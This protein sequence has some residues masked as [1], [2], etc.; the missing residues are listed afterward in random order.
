M[1]LSS[2]AL[3]VTL[4]LVS[5]IYSEPLNPMRP[6]VIKDFDSSPKPLKTSSA[7]LVSPYRAALKSKS[8]ANDSA[9]IAVSP[10]SISVSSVSC[11]LKVG[12]DNQEHLDRYTAAPDDTRTSSRLNMVSDS[13]SSPLSQPDMD[14]PGAFGPLHNT[15]SLSSL[16]YV[17]RLTNTDGESLGVVI[18]PNGKHHH[19][20]Q[21]TWIG[22]NHGTLAVIY[23]DALIVKELHQ[24]DEGQWHRVC[25]KLWSSDK[26]SGKVDIL[27]HCNT[28]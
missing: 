16:R 23:E 12:H 20:Q 26:Y 28:D 7:P 11:R 15:F 8:I 24:D 18:D 13:T 9:K 17:G 21:G 25:K 22:M 27:S 19:V 6:T 2:N 1:F 10:G 14:G 3:I 4:G 5:L